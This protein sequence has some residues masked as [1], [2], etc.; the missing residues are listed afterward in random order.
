MS[1]H[2]TRE[3]QFAG[4]IDLLS[5]RA[6][7]RTRFPGATHKS[8]AIVLHHRSLCPGD[9]WITGKD[10]A[11]GDQ[12]PLLSHIYPFWFWIPLGKLR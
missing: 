12:S 11:A 7:E 4:A 1:V 8:K 9:F 3:N 10:S 5:R 6:G 2:E